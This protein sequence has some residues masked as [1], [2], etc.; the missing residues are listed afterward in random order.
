[1]R[2]DKVAFAI[3]CVKQLK[4]KLFD[5]THSRDRY[6][7]ANETQKS[8]HNHMRPQETHEWGSAVCC[9]LFWRLI[10]WHLCNKSTDLYYLLTTTNNYQMFALSK[11]LLFTPI[12][13]KSLDFCFVLLRGSCSL[14]RVLYLS[15]NKKMHIYS[16]L[17]NHTIY[18]FQMNWYY[19]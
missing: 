8:T 15:M 5:S 9:C 16:I 3:F 17:N 2:K 10:Y 7:F 12:V 14:W 6:E 11:S 18:K 4:L 1:M 13:A 19:F